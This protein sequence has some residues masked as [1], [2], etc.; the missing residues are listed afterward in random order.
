METYDSDS[1]AAY[2]KTKLLFIYM[3]FDPCALVLI[4]TE[5]VVVQSY[6]PVNHSLNYNKAELSLI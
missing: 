5:N 1:V 3:H 2:M 4:H 6:Q